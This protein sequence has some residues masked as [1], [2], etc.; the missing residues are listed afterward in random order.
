MMTKHR[1]QQL[2]ATIK[3]PTWDGRLRKSLSI[4]SCT[5]YIWKLIP[6]TMLARDAHG[7]GLYL[8]TQLHSYRIPPNKGPVCLCLLF[9]KACL[10]FG[11]RLAKLGV[12][13]KIIQVL[14][15]LK[16]LGR[17]KLQK[18]TYLLRGTDQYSVTISSV[19]PLVLYSLTYMGL[20]AQW[21]DKEKR[22]LVQERVVPKSN[23]SGLLDIISSS[24]TD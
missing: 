6:E 17:G 22:S 7:L 16:L 18:L 9:W 15:W 13:K 11:A 20:P 19:S 10:W 24:F 14:Q 12:L 2:T 21:Q 23:L 1:Y 5:I 3:K 4:I 8:G